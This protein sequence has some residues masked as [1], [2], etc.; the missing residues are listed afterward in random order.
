MAQPARIRLLPDLWN[1]A[2]LGDY[3]TR[4]GV[5]GA[6]TQAALSYV[7]VIGSICAVRDVFGSH[8]RRDGLGLFLSLLAIVP[9]LGGFPKTAEVIHT[10]AVVRRGWL[11]MHEPEILQAKLGRIPNPLAVVSLLLAILTPVLVFL[12]GNLVL[13]GLASPLVA[14]LTGHIAVAR[15]RRHPLARARYGTALTGLIL[16]Y[17]F[18]L[19]AAASVALLLTFGQSVGPFLW[20]R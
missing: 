7:P 10:L 14:V 4:L 19:I 18:L 6:V 9:V 20:K 11:A 16:G 5:A 13:V 12:P 2:V 3:A 15:A 8:R 1:G 17:V